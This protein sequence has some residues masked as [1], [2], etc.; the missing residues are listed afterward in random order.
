MVKI[1]DIPDGSGIKIPLVCDFC[2][3]D[4]EQKKRDYTRHH[5]KS[6]YDCCSNRNCINEKT[7]IIKL[8]KYGTVSISEIAKTEGWVIGRKSKYLQ[9]D[10]DNMALAKNYTINTSFPKHIIVDDRISLT[11]NE[12]DTTFETSVWYFMKNDV[13]N[14]PICQ[15]KH[16]SEIQRKCSIEDVQKICDEKNYTLH[17]DFIANCDD[18]VYYTCN[19]HP[20][21]GIQKTS[22]WGLM[23]YKNNCKLCHQ[24]R[25]ENHHNWQGGIAND[26]ERDNDSFEYNR[27]RKDVFQRDNYTC[28]CCGARGVKLNAHHI[29]NYSSNKDLRYDK[30]N[31][32]TLCEECHL[33][34]YP[35]AFH[36]IYGNYNN[37]PD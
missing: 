30:N 7:R 24:P 26:R 20:E 32:I 15:G 27:W 37:T 25:G 29:K 11:C 22:L 10:L 5:K 4:F 8:E 23:H 1:E 9:I 14:C 12:H 33:N 19:I 36:K 31:G 18:I 28:Q 3:C 2:G 34:N 21:Y 17:T 13:I 16:Q 35:E 6:D